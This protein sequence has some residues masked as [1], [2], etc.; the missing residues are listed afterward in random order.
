M[1]QSDQVPAEVK[2]LWSQ[3]FTSRVHTAFGRLAS[4]ITFPMGVQSGNGK[5][6]VLA[7][8]DL[9]LVNTNDKYGRLSHFQEFRTELENIF[10]NSSA[11]TPADIHASLER[12]F[13]NNLMLKGFKSWNVS[14]D[15][16]LNRLPPSVHEN[17][18]SGQD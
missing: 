17:A 8:S 15:A 2:D 3:S 18:L 5:L 12:Q 4:L 7:L 14:L 6:D 13:P 10:Q 11:L 16:T 9:G 1:T